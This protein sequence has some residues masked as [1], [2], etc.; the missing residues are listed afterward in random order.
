MLITFSS[1]SSQ[2]GTQKALILMSGYRWSKKLT[3]FIH[4]HVDVCTRV[5][6]V[7]CLLALALTSVVGSLV[8]TTVQCA[9]TRPSICS[10]QPRNA[11]ERAT[12]WTHL[13][14]TYIRCTQPQLHLS[15][16]LTAVHVCSYVQYMY[17][18]TNIVHFTVQHTH[19]YSHAAATGTVHV[20]T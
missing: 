13:E 3:D 15:C 6:L 8:Q 5:L 18:A 17:I 7:C 11:I 20:R 10:H 2:T 14:I 16:N 1:S 19:T 9:Y 4:V 12:G